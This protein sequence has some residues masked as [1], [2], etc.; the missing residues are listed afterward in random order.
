MDLEEPRKRP[1]GLF[2]WVRI[3]G[4]SMEP[5]A[6]D[7]QVVLA[8][9]GLQPANGDLAVV[10]FLDGNHTFKRVYVRD[11][12]WILAPINPAHEPEFRDRREIRQ[13][14]KVWG[15]KF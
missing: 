13:A 2:G 1:L 7:G 3:D 11:R 15:V 6:R 14:M 9:R 4:A 8:H 10:E 5:L 12:N